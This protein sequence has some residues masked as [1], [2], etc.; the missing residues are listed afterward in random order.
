LKTKDTKKRQ[1]GN[2]KALQ[3]VK[4]RNGSSI[5]RQ[6]TCTFVALNG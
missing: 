2:F 5:G 3:D 4:K 6:N 1:E